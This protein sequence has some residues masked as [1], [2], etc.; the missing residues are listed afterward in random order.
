MNESPIQR[1]SKAR[2]AFENYHNDGGWI[3][4]TIHYFYHLDLDQ[5][6]AANNI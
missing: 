6:M 1:L 3:I 5:I 4:S 2:Y